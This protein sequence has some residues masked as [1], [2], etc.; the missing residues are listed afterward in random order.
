MARRA[1]NR[2]SVEGNTA[3]TDLL[4]ECLG[5]ALMVP[6]R[7]YV[8]P[9]GVMTRRKRFADPRRTVTQSDVAIPFAGIA[10]LGEPTV[11]KS[12]YYYRRWLIAIRSGSA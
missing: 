12:L 3:F 9:I 2:R 7:L 1:D 8:F 11:F 10:E 4:E 6:I 5:L